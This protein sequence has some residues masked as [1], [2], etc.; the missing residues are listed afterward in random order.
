MKLVFF[1]TTDSGTVKGH[2]CSEDL[3]Q[4]I[5]DEMYSRGL[6]QVTQI[7]DRESALVDLPGMVLADR[8]Y[9]QFDVGSF[10]LTIPSTDVDAFYSE[11]TQA[12]L[13]TINDVEFYKI[14]GWV[15]CVILT[16]EQRKSVLEQMENRIASINERSMTDKV[17]FEK[18]ISQINAEREIVIHKPRIKLPEENN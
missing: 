7:L 17:R 4:T 14:H 6:H 13:R 12:R 18:A 10:S 15:H 3:V 2:F 16:P 1:S 9:E 8:S 11:L 5:S